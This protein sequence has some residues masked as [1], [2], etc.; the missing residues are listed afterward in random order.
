MRIETSVSTHHEPVDLMLA[1][2]DLRVERTAIGRTVDSPTGP[3]QEGDTYVLPI[4]EEVV[5]VEK[6]LVLKE[7]VRVTRIRGEH[8]HQ[9][10]V[11]LRREDVRVERIDT[12]TDGKERS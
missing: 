1:R 3:R 5:V 2:D 7:E 10:H 12:P 6:R 4:Y 8:R 9:E 11:E